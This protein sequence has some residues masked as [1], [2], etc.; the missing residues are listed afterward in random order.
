MHNLL[1]AKQI[2]QIIG[3]SRQAIEKRARKEG[4]KYKEIK[5]GR[6]KPTKYYYFETLPSDIKSALEKC[7]Q[8]TLKNATFNEKCQL[9]ELTLNPTNATESVNQSVNYNAT[10]ENKGYKNA[11]IP[12]NTA[13]S[14]NSKNATDKNLENKALENATSI[15]Q[16]MDFPNGFP[17]PNLPNF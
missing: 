14:V 9:N 10:I 17:Y 8:L 5:E 13:E 15:M 4:W 1:T 12:E 11:T 3:K 7:N 2:A 6:G 16:P